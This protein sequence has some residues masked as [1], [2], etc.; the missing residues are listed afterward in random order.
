MDQENET[1]EGN[2]EPTPVEGG[3]DNTESLKYKEDMFRYKREAKAKE[4]E[5]KKVQSELEKVST[6][7]MKKNNQYK[8]LYE[9]NK[10]K[11]EEANQKYESLTEALVTRDKMSAIEKIALKNGIRQEALDDLSML[12]TSSVMIETT[13]TGRTNVIGA[14]EFV[15][16]LKSVKGHWFTP[17]A[18]NVNNGGGQHVSTDTSYTPK[19]LI[20]LEGKDPAKYQEIMTS[21][22]HLIRR[23]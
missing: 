3:A 19:Q 5:L 8:E 13:S 22:R 14:D 21:K 16:S 11:A 7:Q 20:E 4:E 6:E 12:D 17:S 9:Q 18:P 15:Q 10:A 23:S 1:P 2:V